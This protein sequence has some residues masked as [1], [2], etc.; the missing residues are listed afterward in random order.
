MAKRIEDGEPGVDTQSTS[1]DESNQA[2]QSDGKIRDDL[3][4]RLT[5][6]TRIGE[7]ENASG[8]TVDVQN[9]VVTLT[10][11]VESEMAK[12]AAWDDSWNVPGVKDVFNNLRI[13]R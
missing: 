6:D 4:Q 1:S 13:I 7:I 8:I 11:S 3:R 10:G 12:R 9:G 5:E 2:Q